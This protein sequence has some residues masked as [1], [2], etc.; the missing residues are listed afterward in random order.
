[1]ERAAAWFRA[2]GFLVEPQEAASPRLPLRLFVYRR[3][4]E[5]VAL[6]LDRLV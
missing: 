6:L 1:M 3:A 2:E 5:K 4:R